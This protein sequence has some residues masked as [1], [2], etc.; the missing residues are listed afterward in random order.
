MNFES[1]K[2]SNV[3]C[4]QGQ[5]HFVLKYFRNTSKAVIMRKNAFDV[6]CSGS[7]EIVIFDLCA[8]WSNYY[9]LNLNSKINDFWLILCTDYMVCHIILPFYFH[10]KISRVPFDIATSRVL[11][12]SINP[13]TFF[14]LSF[15]LVFSHFWT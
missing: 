6:K 9:H 15:F 8:I 4:Y 11:N 7:I 3:H 5:E 1:W 2:W 13:F 12:N 10:L 14:L